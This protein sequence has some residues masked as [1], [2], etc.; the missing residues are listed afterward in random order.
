VE[1]ENII[2]RITS[3]LTLAVQE[4]GCEI[5]EK[6]NFSLRVLKQ[7]AMKRHGGVELWLLAFLTWALYEEKRSST[8]SGSFS[9]A[10]TIQVSND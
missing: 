7:H 1:K 3:K 8:R 9:T 6:I 10:E 2:Q 4:K 5:E